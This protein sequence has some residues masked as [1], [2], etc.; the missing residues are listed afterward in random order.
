MQFCFHGFPN[1]DYLRQVSILNKNHYAFKVTIVLTL[2]NKKAQFPIEFLSIDGFTDETSLIIESLQK[3]TPL[4]HDVFLHR[5]TG[6]NHT[7][8]QKSNI[9]MI[10]R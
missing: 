3:L 8:C 4:V 9:I 2:W 5:S 1:C 6:S 10:Y 7:H